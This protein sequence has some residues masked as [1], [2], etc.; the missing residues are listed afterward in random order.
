MDG[1]LTPPTMAEHDLRQLRVKQAQLDLF[2]PQ[3]VELIK[4][5]ERANNDLRAEIDQMK[6]EIREIKAKK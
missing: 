2:L 1:Q 6:A 5:Q 4:K 3:L